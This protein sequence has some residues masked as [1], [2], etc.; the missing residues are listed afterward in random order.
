M[1]YFFKIVKGLSPLYLNTR[2]IFKPPQ[3]RISRALSRNSVQITEPQCRL[4]G[5]KKSFFP[6]CTRLWNSLSN[7]AVMCTSIEVFNAHLLSLAVF[8]HCKWSDDAIQ[9][10]KTTKVHTGRLITQF[11]LV[12]SPLRNELFTY[13]ITDNPFC[14]TCGQ[15][16]ETLS[17]FLFECLMYTQQKTIMINDLSVLLAYANRTFNLHLDIAKTDDAKFVL[18]H[19]LNLPI[20]E[21]NVRINIAI[22]QIAS[23]FISSTTR[24]KQHL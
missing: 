6:D 11:R 14:Q 8:A 16:V 4:S 9:Y 22:F 21:D 7:D 15:H 19:G 17:H 5:Y 20:S 10:S 24:F 3:L 18:I 1:A 12:L 13:N 23:T 2:I